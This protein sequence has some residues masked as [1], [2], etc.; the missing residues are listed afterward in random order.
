MIFQYC[1]NFWFLIFLLAFGIFSE[2]PK[3]LENANTL[4]NPKREF[5]L[6]IED[7]IQM[8][9]KRNINILSTKIDL[10]IARAREIQAGLWRNPSVNILRS[11]IPFHSNYNQTSSGGPIQLDVLVNYPLDLSGKI[12]TARNLAEGQKFLQE[13]VLYGVIYET[14]Y[15]IYATYTDLVL[16][17]S[18]KKLYRNREDS[19]TRLVRIIQNRIGGAGLQPLLL[20]RAELALSNAKIDSQNVSITAEIARKNLAL[21]LAFE[22]SP[23]IKPTSALRDFV[24]K[25]AEEFDASEKKMKANYPPFLAAKMI[26]EVANRNIQFNYAKVWSDFN[27]FLGGS[28]QSGVRANPGDPTSQPLPGERSWAVGLTIP[29]PIFDRNQGEISASKLQ[30]EQAE[31]NLRQFE[32]TIEKDLKNTLEKIH[33]YYTI[34]GEMERSQLKKA[35]TVLTTQ[36]KLFGTGG[37]NLLEFF[38]AVTAYT[39]TLSTY[40]T[41]ISE[42]RKNVAKYIFLTGGI[43]ENSK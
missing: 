30:R 2:S 21:L 42:Y 38:D 15:N 40:Y 31:L 32:I 41:T 33:A 18:L 10:D 12:R 39:T 16:Q 8:G 23:N 37:T 20:T 26:V 34:I 36:Q 13:L 17:E 3:D 22:K 27:F 11:L 28:S 9:E 4:E 24:L 14:N 6:S 35:E 43:P 19:L 25:D 29:L 7:C 1:K 5:E